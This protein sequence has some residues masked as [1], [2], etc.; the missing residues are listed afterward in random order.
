MNQQTIFVN[1]EQQCYEMFSEPV[2]F[3]LDIGN[4]QLIITMQDQRTIID[5]RNWYL[6]RPPNIMPSDAVP[7]SRREKEP[8]NLYS[9]IAQ[10]WQVLNGISAHLQ[11]PAKSGQPMQLG[12]ERPFCFH[13]EKQTDTEDLPYFQNYDR[14][15][16]GEKVIRHVHYVVESAVKNRATNTETD[17]NNERMEIEEL[18]DIEDIMAHVTGVK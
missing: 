14:L 2:H 5:R 15:K 4:E 13:Y 9:L 6:S 16:H 3:P 12:P 18:T 8:I 1:S 11:I 17:Q 10:L 7:S